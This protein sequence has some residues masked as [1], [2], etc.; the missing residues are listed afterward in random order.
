MK[1]KAHI[2]VKLPVNFTEETI[3]HALRKQCLNRKADNQLYR[4]FRFIGGTVK[5]IF[6]DLRGYEKSRDVKT[7]CILFRKVLHDCF[8]CPFESLGHAIDYS[9]RDRIVFEIT[10]NGE[11]KQ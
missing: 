2:T 6:G 9:I 4:R 1:I 3:L 11:S 5:V 7:D 10:M 8:A